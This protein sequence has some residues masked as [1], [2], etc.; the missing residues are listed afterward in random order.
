MVY[1]FLQ[2]AVEEELAECANARFW[3]EEDQFYLQKQ[4]FLPEK[5]S[6]NTGDWVARLRYR[7]PLIIKLPES[8]LGIKKWECEVVSNS[9]VATFIKEFVVKLPEGE[10]LNFEPGGYIQIDVPKVPDDF[11]G[12]HY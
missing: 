6:T 12:F 1:F 5:N 9:N 4:V 7:E 10:Q 11:Q 2:P 8:V 3:R